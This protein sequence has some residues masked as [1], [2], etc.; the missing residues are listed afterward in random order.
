MLFRQGSKRPSH[1]GDAVL[2]MG[3]ISD[4]QVSQ[5]LFPPNFNEANTLK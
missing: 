5:P 4:K 3:K 2:N 1:K